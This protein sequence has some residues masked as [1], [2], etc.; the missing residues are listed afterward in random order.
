MV[1]ALFRKAAAE[2]PPM[3]AAVESDQGAPPQDAAVPPAEDNPAAQILELLDVEL[4]AMIRQL[5]RA[6]ASVAGGA[7]STAETLADIRRRTEALTGRRRGPLHRG[8]LFG[9]RRQ[10]HGIGRRHRRAGA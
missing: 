6:A 8:D 7:R 2:A 4:Q 3:K 10:V 5:E 1:F 9:G